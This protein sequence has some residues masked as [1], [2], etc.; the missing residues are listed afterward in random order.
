MGEYILVIAVLLLSLY[1]CAE[2]VRCIALRILKTDHSISPV[3]VLPVSGRCVNVEFIIRAAVSHSRWTSDS[4][5]R[6]L[7]LDAGMD[8]ETLEIV[9]K[10]C[11]DFSNI[12]VI[13]PGECEKVIVSGLQ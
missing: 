5:G 13:A 3:L 12:S 2:L 10:L 4:P 9:K 6:V 7:I 1:G 8:E 11:D